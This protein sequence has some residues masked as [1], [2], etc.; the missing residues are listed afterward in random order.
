M[1]N[2]VMILVSAVMGTLIMV[3]VMTIQGRMNRSVELQSNLSNIVETT[4]K[5]TVEEPVCNQSAE[6]MTADCILNLAANMDTDS[7]LTVDVMK[8][9]PEKGLLSIRVEE[10][11]IHPNGARGSTHW[12]RTAIYDKKET[13]GTETYKVC[14]YKSKSQMTENGDCYKTYMV[15][16][17]THIAA[18][19]APV[20]KEGAFVC[21][22]DASD[23]VADF[24]VPVEQD[25]IY[26]AEWRPD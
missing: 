20:K 25:L 23:Y 13:T 11:F 24:S 12:E 14:F 22:K 3:M 5:N 21:W 6:E 18:P 2:M 10:Q 15:Q 1:K 8:A 7:D 19:A 16:S 17:G 9:D 4:V 26:Y